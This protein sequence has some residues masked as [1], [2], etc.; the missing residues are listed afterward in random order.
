MAGGSEGRFCPYAGLE[1]HFRHCSETFAFKRRTTN[2]LSHGSRKSKNLIKLRLGQGETGKR[3]RVPA[4]SR[5]EVMI[6]V[7]S[8]RIDGGG[9]LTGRSKGVCGSSGVDACS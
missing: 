4:A 5:V 1:R 6:R 3:S 8:S 7:G 2:R 9:G